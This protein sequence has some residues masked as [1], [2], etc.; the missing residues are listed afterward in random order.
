ML[1][2]ICTH[3]HRFLAHKE[4]VSWRENWDFLNC[5]C[6]LAKPDGLRM[7]EHFLGGLHSAAPTSYSSLQDQSVDA[8]YL[9]MDSILEDFSNLSLQDPV[10]TPKSNSCRFITG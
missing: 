6:D 3:T 2:S 9:E 10:G 4:K 1:I 8:G 5:S 7:L